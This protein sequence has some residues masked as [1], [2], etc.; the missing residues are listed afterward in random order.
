MTQREAQEVVVA[1]LNLPEVR[2]AF[3][4]LLVHGLL[5]VP[6][7][8]TIFCAYCGGHICFDLAGR[9]ADGVQ[10]AYVRE[11]V[12]EHRLSCPEYQR[13]LSDLDAD[14]MGHH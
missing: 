10:S 5:T 3:A 9:P 4:T 14:E 1:K 13:K 2:E 8:S 7:E 11:K 6:R 12:S